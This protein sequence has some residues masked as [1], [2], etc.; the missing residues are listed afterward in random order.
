VLLNNPQTLLTTPFATVTNLRET[1]NELG[2]IID[3]DDDVVMV[4]LA[5]RGT[6]EHAL[7]AEQPPL[8]LVDLTP[9]GLKQLLDDAGI[10]WRIIVVSSCYSGAFA[11]ALADDHTLVITDAGVDGSDGVAFGC[12][13]RTPPTVFGDAFFDQGLA[14]GD[15]FQAA[16][17]RAKAAVAAREQEEKYAPPSQPTMIVGS[18]MVDKLKSVR[19][20][21]AGGGLT[22]QR[23][24]LPRRG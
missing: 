18:E 24:P 5:S 9:V 14:K 7:V 17:E 1:L 8:S 13:G 23:A 3:A 21:G 15:T 2:A 20:R 12:D 22:A 10:K 4:Y 16:F 19:S 11:A 6:R